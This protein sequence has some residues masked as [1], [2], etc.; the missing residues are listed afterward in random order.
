VTTTPLSKI[1]V[2]DLTTVVVGPACT[3]RLADYGAE[4]I[5]VETQTGD[6]LRS[7]GGQSPTGRHGGGYLHLNRKKRTVCL[8]LKTAGGRGALLAIAAGCDVVV[9]NMRP[10]ALR[11]LGI[12]ADSLRADRP[13]LIF[14][15]ISGFGPGGPYTGKPA[16]DS[17]LQ[18]SSGVAGLF[19]QRDG[20]PSYVPLL[21]CDHIVGEIAAGA[22]LAA[23]FERRGTGIGA[24]IEVPMH[25]TMAAFVLSEHMGSQSFEPTLGP[26]GDARL[27]DP[28]NRPLETQDGWICVTANTDAQVTAFFEAVG[29]PDLAADPR[30]ASVASRLANVRDWYAE[31]A[32]AVRTIAT[33]DL[34]EVLGKADVPVMPCHTLA[35]LL[36]DAHLSAVG[37]LASDQH[38]TEGQVRSIRPTILHDGQASDAGRPAAP[39]GFDTKTVLLAAGF[40]ANVIDALIESRAA[41]QW[42]G[43]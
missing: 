13:D 7:L 35:T 29:R 8:D 42:G 11:R 19:A 3:Q 1:K 30:F 39:V 23:L 16:Y 14:C 22:I 9:S 41:T 6:V 20:T 40:N 17:V 25:E 18:G 43:A 5:K 36:G 33:S 10:D 2:L 26:A 31:R 37:L 21:L 27:L 4:V 15:L 28:N 12:D 38:P 24:A 34:L 32:A